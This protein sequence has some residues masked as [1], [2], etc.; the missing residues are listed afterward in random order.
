MKQPNM[1][2]LHMFN[3]FITEYGK[4]TAKDCK[5]NWQRMAADWHPSNGF[6]PLATRL[7]IGASYVSTACYPRDDCDVINI[8]LRVIKHCEMYS[9]EYKNW[10]A[11]E[12]ETPAIVKTINSVKEYWANVIALVNQ[13][14]VL[15]SQ[16][17]YGMAAMDDNTLLTSYSESLAN[18]GAAYAAT[19]ESI[20]T[21]GTSLATMQDQLTNI[22]QFCMNVGQQPH[23]TSMPPLNNST[24][25]TIVLADA[26]AVVPDAATAVAISHNNQ[27]G[28]AAAELA[29]SNPLILLIPINVGRIGTT[30]Q[31]M[32]VTLMTG[33][34]VQRVGIGAWHTILT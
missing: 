18:F 11:H 4:T 34:Q 30:A 7:F 15:A 22:Q 12:K 5:D 6:E 2:F 27:P 19:Q 23:P 14:A 32:A 3:W 31:C 9:E 25:P 1:V 17:G 26:T 13:T 24:R 29:H 21:H 28:L 20:K 10:I 8:G 33:T 16:H